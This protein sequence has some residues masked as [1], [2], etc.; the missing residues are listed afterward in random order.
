MLKEFR[1]FAMKGNV[2]DLAVGV[3]IG[4]AFGAIV[5]SLVGDVIMPVIGAITGGLDFSN[6]FI[7]LSKE[8]TATNLVDAKK[9]GAVLAY[10]SFLTVTLNF[11]IIAFVLFIVIRL[12][13]RIK[14]SEEAKP[15][16]APAPTKDQVLLT[17]IRDILKTK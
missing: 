7:G 11:L 10:G 16:E 1:E 5:S 3:I 14:R 13:N 6:Y 12:I 2:V 8:V 4:A 15:A 17:E 9:Q